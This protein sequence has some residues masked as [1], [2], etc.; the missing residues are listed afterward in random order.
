[1]NRI[2]AKEA[3]S[4]V[5]VP[6]LPVQFAVFLQIRFLQRQCPHFSDRIFFTVA[7]DFTRFPD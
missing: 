7:N 3:A 5:R 4:S 1:M 6:R 2:G